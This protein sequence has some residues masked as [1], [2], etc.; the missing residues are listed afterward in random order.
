MK[1]LILAMF[2][3]LIVSNMF[4][5]ENNGTPVRVGVNI[6]WF[7]SATKTDDG[8]I[9]YAWSDTRLAERDIYVQKV[10]ENGDFLWGDDG[11]TVNAYANRQED[12]V[13]IDSG[14][15]SV[16]TAWIDFRNSDAGDVFAQ[17]V[18]ADGSLLWDIDGVP[19]C[20]ADD[21]QISLNIIND[22]DGGAYVIW[23]DGRNPG[24]TSIYGSHIL[25]SGAIAP[26][27]AANGNV[28]VDENGSQN[29][30][31]FWEDGQGG[32]ILA[33]HDTRVD[34][35]KNVYMQR[36]TSDG[37]LLWGPGGTLLCD[38]ETEQDKPKVTPD[39]QGN[40]IFAW[41]DRRNDNNGDIYAQKIDLDGNPQ[42]GTGLSGVEVYTGPTIQKNPRITKSSDGGAFIVWEDGRVNPE[43]MDIY[44]QKLNTNGE[45]QWNT[46]GV[47]VT[48][49]SGE[50]QDQLNPRLVGDN[51]GGTWIIWDDARDGGFPNVD[52]YTQHINASGAAELDAGG[53]MI[54]DDSGEQ[55]SPLIKFSDGNVFLAW[56]DGDK[57]VGA[58]SI[59]LQILDNNGNEQLPVNGADLY[60]GICG[61]A[62]NLE[63][64]EDSSV[65]VALWEDSRDIGTRIY[66]QVINNNGSFGLVE[67]G[68]PLA[69]SSGLDQLELNAIKDTE[70]NEFGVVWK[71]IRD[72]YNYQIFAQIMSID[73]TLIGP[74]DGLLL[75]N[76]GLSDQINAKIS[77]KTSGNTTD[78]YAG[79]S[80]GRI[81][82]MGM[83][84]YAQK[85]VGGQI[86]WDAEGV[87]VVNPVEGM[88]ATL[89]AVVE[90]YY[91]YRRGTFSNSDV[92]VQKMDEDGNVE[93]GWPEDGYVLCSAAGKQ[94]NAQAKMTPEGLLVIWEDQRNGNND[95]YGQMIDADG[96]TLWEDDGTAM[97]DAAEDQV[98]SEMIYEDDIYLTWEDFRDGS[99]NKAYTQRFNTD[100]TE[101]W[102]ENGIQMGI[103]DSTQ[104]TPFIVHRNYSD[105]EFAVLWSYN[106]GGYSDLFFRSFDEAGNFDPIHPA[107]GELM[108]NALHK[109]KF[110]KAV[111]NNE[112]VL[113]VW[114]DMRSSGKTEI[115][116]IY[117]QRMDFV[118]AGE[119]DVVPSIASISQ[120]YPNPFNPTTTI[121]YN[122]SAEYSENAELIIYNLKGQKVKSFTLS[123]QPELA[124]GSVTWNGTDSQDRKV[125]SGLY[126]YKIESDSK[127]SETKKMV[128]L[129]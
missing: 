54:C 6:E 115:Y 83:G 122:L 71:E 40:F 53:K 65:S 84:V 14:D 2:A 58:N 34:D 94:Q 97:V 118:G 30:H 69:A 11:I 95:I 28:I 79:W 114:E 128:L 121:S 47:A 1:K 33:W 49:D 24:G 37:T 108:C 116:S 86:Q 51:S 44:A 78:Y 72:N 120:N 117:A 22:A 110:P 61:D 7:R 92:F 81:F 20:V 109:Q 59:T 25:A 26:G 73:G 10:D 103:Q 62:R 15:G 64:L 67:N 77:Y 12:I 35:D 32:G 55:F 99:D 21:I 68:V 96:N 5:W 50:Q 82:M 56:G 19:L 45:L 90:N 101:I 41:R 43:K 76:N 48:S 98:I 27:W 8:N 57:E 46:D 85:I 105:Y 39:G 31:T 100:G 127:S 80:D 107:E 123:N 112:D 89:M 17:K 63:L 124:E 119:E 70:A 91:V 9:V 16:I 87:I 60:G 129:K 36:F 88:D 113:V 125:S 75:C 23:L 52:I 13:V 38:V 4:A 74:E 126:L 102:Q 106:F 3:L 42:W 29:Q 93:A 18:A 104:S 111:L 66:A